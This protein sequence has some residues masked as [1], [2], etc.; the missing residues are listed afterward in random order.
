MAPND[1]SDLS[2]KFPHKILVVED[3]KLNLEIIVKVLTSLGYDCD[4]AENGQEAVELCTE[5]NYSLI[6]MDINMPLMNGIEATQQILEIKHNEKPKIVALT[7]DGLDANKSA[8]LEVGMSGFIV[9]PINKD[10]IA[11]FIENLK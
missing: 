10:E 7:A 3:N 5:N 4:K 9:K 2:Q 6:F 11:T 1:L 8:C